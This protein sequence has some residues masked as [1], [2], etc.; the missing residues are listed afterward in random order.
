MAL[1]MFICLLE[2]IMHIYAYKYIIIKSRSHMNGIG[3]SSSFVEKEFFDW[4]I[5]YYIDCIKM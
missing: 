4:T 5:K 2:I 1:T 3:I